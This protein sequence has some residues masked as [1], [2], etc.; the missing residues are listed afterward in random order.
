VPVFSQN[1]K[2]NLVTLLDVIRYCGPVESGRYKKRT[3][4][5]LH[6]K[7]RKQT[8]KVDVYTPRTMYPETETTLGVNS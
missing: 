3:V 8:G 7:D 5:T 1:R 6:E 2:I 4:H